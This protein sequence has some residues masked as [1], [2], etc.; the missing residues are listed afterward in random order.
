MRRFPA[1]LVLACV[2]Y[3]VHRALVLHSDFDS[4]SIP[5]YELSAM[6]NIAWVLHEG[7]RGVP[8]SQF[9]DNC[10]GHLA[11]GVLAAPLYALFGPSY[12]TLKLVPVLLGLGCIP[13]VWSIGRRLFGPVA[14][15]VAAWLFVLGPP[16]LTKYSMLAK[17]NHFENVFFQMLVL[18]TFVRMHQS[19]RKEIR[20]PAFALASGFAIFFYFGSALMVA[21]L[22]ALHFAIRFGW[23]L[24]PGAFARPLR[25]AAIGLVPFLVGL[26][27]LYLIQSANQR[28]GEFVSSWF[29]DDGIQQG[30]RGQLH[31]LV[32]ELLPRATVYEDLGPIPGALADR[33]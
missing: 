16:T 15:A 14:G 33:A 9:Y 13:L 25:D 6:G 1:A 12:L 8:L 2:T 3:L 19:T 31:D 30:F 11:V 27:P 5:N 28:P 22:F 7:W 21:V 24:S 4:V 29:L 26:L 32:F 18:W 23:T 10:G 17:G 20:L